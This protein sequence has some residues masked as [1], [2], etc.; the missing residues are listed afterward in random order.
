MTLTIGHRF[1]RNETSNTR[2]YTVYTTE[3][4]YNDV[5]SC[6]TSAITLYILWYQL[7][8]HTARVFLPRI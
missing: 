5:G 1:G 2:D 6:D 7:I 3:L 8:F 4:G